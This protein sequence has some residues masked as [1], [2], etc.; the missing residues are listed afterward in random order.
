MNVVVRRRLVRVQTEE[1][2]RTGIP[3]WAYTILGLGALGSILV[4]LGIGAVYAIYANYTED[5]VPIAD[6]IKQRYVG[7]TEVYDRGG[8]TDGVFLGTLANPNAQLLNPVPLED[9]SPYLVNSTIST[10]DNSF[11]DNPGVDPKALVRAAWE[12]YSGGGVGSGTGGSSITQQLVKNVYLSDD[13]EIIDGVKSC[14]AP[15]TLE[16]KLKEIAYSLEVQQEYT[17]KQVFNLIKHYEKQGWVFLYLGADHDV[18]AAGRDLGIAGDGLISFCRST[19]DHTFDQLSEA[20]ARYRR[21]DEHPAADAFRPHETPP[22]P[23]PSS[24]DQDLPSWLN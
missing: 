15:R 6:K 19:V 5:Y 16:R 13:C 14:V 17:K 9:I 1:P 20:T 2:G 21:D 7:L 12:N 24:G 22:S 23:A 10:E 8:P 4:A 18:W 11:W 3:W